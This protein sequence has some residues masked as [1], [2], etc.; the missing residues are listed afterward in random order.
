[1]AKAKKALSMLLV[2]LMTMFTFMSYVPAKA[3]SILPEVKFVGLENIPAA[4]GEE[5]TLMLTSN[6]TGDVQYRVFYLQ[7]DDSSKK[8]V[9]GWKALGDWTPA[10][11]AKTPVEVKVPAGTITK[12][13]NYSFAVRVKMA[14]TDGTYTNN[15]GGYDSAYAFDYVFKAEPT[16]G[17]KSA[18]LEKNE[19]VAEEK[20]VISGL[21]AGESYRLFTLNED[22]T[23]RWDK[24]PV[25]TS[26]T[27]KIE[28]APA[29]A[30]NYVLDLQLMKDGKPGAVKLF[31]VKVTPKPTELK[32]EVSA[33]NLKTMTV[34]FN[35]EV[36]EDTLSATTVK[37]YAN[38]A[39]SALALDDNAGNP[40]PNKAGYVLSDDNKS[41]T[42]VFGT[43]FAQS[44]KVKLTINGLKDINGKELKDFSEEYAVNDTTIPE[45]SGVNAINAKQIELLFSE[46]MSSLTNVAYQVLNNIKIDGV[47]VIAK[48]T[49]NYAKNSVILELSTALKAGAHKIDVEDVLDFAGYKAVKKSFDF[50]IVE[51]KDAPKL[52]KAEVKNINEIE[53][54]FDEPLSAIGTYTVNGKAPTSVKFVSNSN[55]TK[56]DLSGNITL[57]LSAIVEVKVA[58]KGQMDLLNN[59]VKDEVVYTFKIDDDTALPAVSAEVKAGNK[60]V[61][62]FTKSMLTDVGTI[63]LI[64]E[65]KN[66]VA[67]LSVKNDL[68]FK[69]GTNNTVIELSAAKLDLA[70][71]NPGDYTL[72]IK[73]MKDA[74]VRANLLPEQNLAIKALDTKKPTALD[75]YIIT[76]GSKS[77]HSDDT[78]TIF[79]SEAMDTAT[80]NNLSNYVVNGGSP[81]AAVSGVSIESIA[82]DNKSVVIV[83]PGAF[84]VETK[85]I[86]TVY[87]LKDLAGNMCV[88]N[89]AV[90]YTPAN[91]N[92]SNKVNAKATARN[93]ITLEFN[94]EIKAIDPSF[95]K[96]QKDAGD[97]AVPVLA[98]IGSD[99]KNVTF[100]LNKDLE[101][102]STTGYSV[103][104]NNITLATNVYG[105][106]IA[107]DKTINTTIIDKIAPTIKSVTLKDETNTDTIVLTFNEN[108]YANTDLVVYDLVVKDLTDDVQLL[109]TEYTV[110]NASGK[111]EIKVT[112]AGITAHK[113]SVKLL[114]GRYISDGSSYSTANNLAKEFDAMTVKDAS[115]NDVSITVK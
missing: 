17:L 76:A 86:F 11:D 107:A 56:V 41:L 51:D 68:T 102:T 99:A 29:E 18:K 20:F 14:G 110:S 111:I 89:N 37:V 98:E 42:V 114:N 90:S 104:G 91:T 58:Y 10:A 60:V 64:D 78:I 87:A 31:N 33:T 65:D 75:N 27:D 81:L 95:I 85:P 53:L 92:L 115:G 101:S 74:S 15:Y 59:Q 5:Q 82:S 4:V 43:K 2:V 93:K 23:P 109:P 106:S 103:V 112:K 24:D 47:A 54:T 69:A 45:L 62:T 52:L 97:F 36:D 100:T 30:G 72:N 13:G 12:A 79:F 73:G 19:V 83:Y 113:F 77:D 108:V 94:T 84:T 61:L 71:V 8:V 7:R 9:E 32:A 46:P 80:V 40:G 63:K 21:T 55:N 39:S 66:V 35:N 57:D 1:M 88:T 28:W 16:E 44:S 48:A 22:R 105:S 34:N 3:A 26:V 49:P 67:N 50:A 70:D 38:G 25:A 6:Y 96:V